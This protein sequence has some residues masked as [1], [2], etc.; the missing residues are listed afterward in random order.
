M[1]VGK[2]NSA[3]KRFEEILSGRSLLWM[4]RRRSVRLDYL[5]VDCVRSN[6]LLRSVVAKCGWQVLAG[7]PD[8]ATAIFP[9]ITICGNAPSLFH[10]VGSVR[11]PSDVRCATY[12]SFN[13]DS[14]L[15]RYLFSPPIYT[16]T[17]FATIASEGS[18][19]WPWCE[20][21]VTVPLSDGYGRILCEISGWESR[22]RRVSY[23]ACAALFQTDIGGVGYTE[24]RSHHQRSV[25]SFTLSK[26]Y[27]MVSIAFKTVYLFLALFALPQVLAAPGA[28]AADLHK[29]ITDGEMLT[30][31]NEIRGQYGSP[32]L[33]WGANFAGVARLQ[34][35][36]CLKTE[37][38]GVIGTTTDGL[39]LFT[40]DTHF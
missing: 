6:L 31:H 16:H 25:L 29:R 13:I 27:Q 19:N 11:A 17:R 2:D 18:S 10:N 22:T 21:P 32:P 35:A 9:L 3:R 8:E 40:E 1:R 37:V 7:K 26:P 33:T 39:S 23:P 30:M 12:Y 24:H 28:A 20:I 14:G 15:V 5:Q 36:T 34:V 4:K 38:H